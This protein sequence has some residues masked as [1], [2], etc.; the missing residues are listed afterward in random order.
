MVWIKPS[1]FGVK[2]RH[3]VYQIIECICTTLRIINSHLTDVL[4]SVYPKLKN[5][6][7]LSDYTL[8]KYLVFPS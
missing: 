2:T 3:N 8:Y 6:P 4:N 7:L 5:M 1:S